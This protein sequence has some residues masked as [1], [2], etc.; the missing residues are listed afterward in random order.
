M[1][2]ESIEKYGILNPLIVRPVPDGVYEIISGHRRKHAAEL[3]GYRKVPV[4]IRVMTEDESILNMVDSQN[5]YLLSQVDE[6]D[7]KEFVDQGKGTATVTP[8]PQ[9]VIDENKIER[10]DKKEEA[11]KT[12]KEKMPQ[13]NMGAMVAILILALGGVAAYYYFKIYKPKKEEEE[14]FEEEG[15]EISDGLESINE[16]EFEDREEENE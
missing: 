12:E 7:L 1:L 5:V 11:A 14:D 15:L 8:T 4:L 16:D 3:L 9:V 6:N 10:T 2:K 13:T